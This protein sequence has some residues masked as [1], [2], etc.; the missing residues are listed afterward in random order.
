[1]Q[2]TISPSLQA[3]ISNWAPPDEIG[4]F[5]SAFL[6]SGIGVV[7]DWCMSGFIIE[8]FGWTYAFY[9]CAAVL[10]LFS[11]VW[12]SVFYDCPSDH[13]K[14]SLAEKEFILSKL[15]VAKSKVFFSYNQWHCS[16][17]RPSK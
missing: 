10:G 5:Q 3:A 15:N 8:H 7:I 2:G 16:Q 12:F 1:M 4:K 11:I 14:I 13:P 9:A 17:M 6:A